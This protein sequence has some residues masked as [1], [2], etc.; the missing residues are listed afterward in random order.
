MAVPKR[1]SSTTRRDKRKTHWK[2]T[3]PTLSK[4]SHCGQVKMAHKICSNCGYYAGVE[5][6]QPAE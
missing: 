6:R 2:L 5:V 3:A 4:C 1:K